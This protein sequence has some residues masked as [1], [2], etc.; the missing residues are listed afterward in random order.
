MPIDPLLAQA[1]LHALARLLEV[2]HVAHRL[3]VSEEF[4]RRLIRD[5]KLAAIRLGTR[6]RIDPID[7]KAFI[8]AQRVASNGYDR[9]SATQ[10][11]DQI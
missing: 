5:K 9:P 10:T 7:L 3:S 11:G 4:V 1:P 2:S 6:W 8:D